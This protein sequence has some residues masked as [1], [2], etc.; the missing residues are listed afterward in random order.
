MDQILSSSEPLP[1]LLLSSS[2]LSSRFLRLKP[3]LMTTPCQRKDD[4]Y[5]EC[6][7]TIQNKRNQHYGIY[8]F[9]KPTFE[10]ECSCKAETASC[11]ESERKLRV[12]K[13]T[14]FLEKYHI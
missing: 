12:R 7:F 6:S 10:E 5:Y 8:K 4:S 14:Y 3:Y 13:S 11:D 1:V 9:M 2:R